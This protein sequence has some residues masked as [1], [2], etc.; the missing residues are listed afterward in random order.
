MAIDPA[1][2]RISYHRL[3][4]NIFRSVY[5]LPALRSGIVCIAD[6]RLIPRKPCLE[7]INPELADKNLFSG[8]NLQINRQPIIKP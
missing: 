1:N 3:A 5:F 4:Q 6:R 8:R 2:V 7:L